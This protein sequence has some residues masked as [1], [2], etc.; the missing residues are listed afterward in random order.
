MTH[1][2]CQE[3]VEVPHT[4]FLSQTLSFHLI[5]SSLPKVLKMRRARLIFP[6]RVFYVD[7]L[8][9]SLSLLLQCARFSCFYSVILCRTKLFPSHLLLSITVNLYSNSSSLDNFSVIL[10]FISV[11]NIICLTNLQQVNA[12]DITPDKQLIAAAGML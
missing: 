4:V 9:I 7:T 3:S 5:L 2:V 12:L 8:V 1:F 10:K 6:K 11:S